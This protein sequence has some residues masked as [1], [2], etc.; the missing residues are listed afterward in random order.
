MSIS[1]KRA[2][3]SS[4][5]ISLNLIDIAPA[6]LNATVLTVTLRLIKLLVK[7]LRPP[8]DTK[9]EENSA[10]AAEEN[11]STTK[12]VVRFLAGGEEVRR[13]PVRALAD[14]IGNGNQSCFLAARSRH[15]SRLPRQLQVETV[16]GAADQQA[17]TE[18]ASADVGG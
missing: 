1:H 12:S 6:P 13:E 2:Q 8:L 17:G 4:P 3:L 9:A 15:Q 11:K 16:V 14:A 18:V 7:P 5:S 10:K